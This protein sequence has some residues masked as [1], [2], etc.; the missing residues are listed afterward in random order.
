MLIIADA[1]DSAPPPIVDMHANT[2][3]AVPTQLVVA[4]VPQLSTVALPELPTLPTAASL[5]NTSF[6]NSSS[7]GTSASEPPPMDNMHSNATSAVPTQLA[8]A[9][10][11]PLPTVA[12]P[13][14]PVLSPAKRRKIN[15]NV[16][17]LEKATINRIIK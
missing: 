3:S 14:L 12:P 7:I 16:L 2:I 9:H 4:C 11:P 15:K 6:D 17:R 13:E 8:A 1:S 10:V 5:P